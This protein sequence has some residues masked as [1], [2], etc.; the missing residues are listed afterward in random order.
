MCQGAL[1]AVR[2]VGGVRHALGAGRECRYLG[3]QGIGEIRGA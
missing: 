2:D 3:Q 1:G